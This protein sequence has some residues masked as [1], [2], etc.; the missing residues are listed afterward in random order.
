V[1]CQ[2]AGWSAAQQAGGIFRGFRRHYC[3]SAAGEQ[4]IFRFVLPFQRDLNFKPY[5][6]Y[7]LETSEKVAFLFGQWYASELAGLLRSRLPA[8][9]GA[10]GEGSPDIIAAVLQVSNLYSVCSAFLEKL[11]S[12]NINSRNW[13]KFEKSLFHSASGMPVSCQGVHD[14]GTAAILFLLLEAVKL[15]RCFFVLLVAMPV[16][17]RAAGGDTV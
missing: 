6:Q 10:L 17:H 11:F 13:R 2:R 16:S 14:P 8:F 9:L 15:L 3:G 12:S 4:S 5:Q 1:V 7:K